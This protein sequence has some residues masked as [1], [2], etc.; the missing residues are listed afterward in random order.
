MFTALKAGYDGLVYAHAFCKLHLS[1]L[2]V[3]ASSL[4]SIFEFH[5]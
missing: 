5:M 1:E 4:D 3:F 2:G